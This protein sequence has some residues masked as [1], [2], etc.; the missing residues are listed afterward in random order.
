MKRYRAEFRQWQPQYRFALH[1]VSVECGPNDLAR[2][3]FRRLGFNTSTPE[4]SLQ[5][6]VFASFTEELCTTD[7]AVRVTK[8]TSNTYKDVISTSIKAVYGETGEVLI[9][10]IVEVF[11]DESNNN[12]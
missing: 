2:F 12:K 6:G 1:E 3:T 10:D 8:A 11:S 4:I 7:K 9:D 5:R